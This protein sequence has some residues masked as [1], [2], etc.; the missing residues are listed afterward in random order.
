M[1]VVIPHKAI[2]VVAN[3]KNPKQAILDFVGDLSEVNIPLNRIL[4][5]TYMRPERTKGGII[6]PDSNKEEDVWQGK[7][8]LVLK[9]GNQAYEDDHEYR[10]PAEDK[11]QPGDWI[12]CNTVDARTIIV[13]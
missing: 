6:R 13:R 7:V 9:W 1:G 2:D 3:A 5:G 4:V 10:F 8:H 12:V 11:A